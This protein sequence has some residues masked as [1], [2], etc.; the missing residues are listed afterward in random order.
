MV[1]VTTNDP[2][3]LIE[4]DRFVAERPGDTRTPIIVFNRT[5]PEAWITA[6]PPRSP[7]LDWSRTFHG[8]LPK[9]RTNET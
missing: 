2:L 3:P 8:G 4:A 1:L 5:L 9:R 6:H 7:T